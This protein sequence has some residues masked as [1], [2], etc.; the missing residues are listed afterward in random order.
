MLILC[1]VVIVS[2]V[3]C[4]SQT[5]I[6]QQMDRWRLLPRPERFTELYFTD[7]RSLPTSV[8]AGTVQHILFTVHNSE[9]RKTTYH[10]KLTVNLAN[11]GAKIQVGDGLFTLA[12]N[13]AR[14]LH[15]TVTVPLLNSRA[16]ISVVLD[17]QGIVAGDDALSLE[18]QSI[19]F[20][21]DI[22]QKPNHKDAL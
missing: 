15:Q 11:N 7:L 6:A 21:A 17:Y 3:V 18:G 12:A 10:Y 22:T 13:E 16:L 8:K 20:W 2:A 4:M 9:Y 5:A 14:T 19:D 1:S